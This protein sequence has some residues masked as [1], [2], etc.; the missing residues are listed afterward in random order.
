MRVESQAKHSTFCHLGCNVE[1]LGTHAIRHWP[2]HSSTVCFC[3]IRNVLTNRAIFIWLGLSGCTISL[4][5]CSFVLAL[6][7]ALAFLSQR[8]VLEV[9]LFCFSALLQCCGRAI[10]IHV[11]Q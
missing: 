1:V 10:R 6:H 4:V 7:S 3:M 8:F 5:R 11:S 2:L 9:T